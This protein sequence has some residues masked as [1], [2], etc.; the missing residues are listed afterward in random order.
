MGVPLLSHDTPYWQGLLLATIAV[1][2]LQHAI[3][4]QRCR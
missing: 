1:V 2:L 3:N 4:L